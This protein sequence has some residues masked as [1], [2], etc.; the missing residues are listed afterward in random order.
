MSLAHA[1]PDGPSACD[2][3]NAVLL[4]LQTIARHAAGPYQFASRVLAQY[5][6]TTSML[7]LAISGCKPGAIKTLAAGAATAA[8]ASEAGTP[9]PW[10]LPPAHFPHIET[11][12]GWQPRQRPPGFL[13]RCTSDRRPQ[14]PT[15]TA[16]RRERLTAMLA[17]RSLLP[18]S[19]CYA[20]C[21]L[22][23]S[24]NVDQNSRAS[25]QLQPAWGTSGPA[26]G[27]LCALQSKRAN[28][29]AAYAAAAGLTTG[30]GAGGVW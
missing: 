10:R 1:A 24:S 7:H 21:V 14:S 8:T 11:L 13:P 22:V 25:V 17:K 29:R 20:L 27:P 28:L 4:V 30:R 23:V 5:G 18:K 9:K 15:A 19:R 2:T 16:C 12:R 3:R 26:N 6:E